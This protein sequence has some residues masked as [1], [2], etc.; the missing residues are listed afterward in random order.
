MW[1][2]EGFKKSGP[3][4]KKTGYSKQEFVHAFGAQNSVETDI[5]SLIDLTAEWD[6]IRKEKHFSLRQPSIIM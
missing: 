4:G 3:I 1:Q 6:K 2:H 5:T